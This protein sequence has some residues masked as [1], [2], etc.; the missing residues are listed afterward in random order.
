[1]NFRLGCA[2]FAVR[3]SRSS[4][5]VVMDDSDRL[6]ALR[7]ELKRRLGPERYEL[8]LGPQTE[9]SLAE[10]VLEVRCTSAA[11]GQWLRRRWHEHLLAC[12]AAILGAGLSINYQWPVGPGASASTASPPASSTS[13]QIAKPE[14]PGSSAPAPA[15]MVSDPAGPPAPAALS[16]LPAPDGS[17]RG[18]FDDFVIGD[19][20][21]LA[22]QA[23][24][25]L[26]RQ[27]GLFSPLLIYGP[28]GSGKS[29]LLQAINHHA[30][31][32]RGRV[33]TLQLTAEQFTTQFLEAL[34]ARSLPGF[35]QKTRNLDLLIV[36]DVQFLETKRA[37]LEEL[38]HT[39][40]ALEARGG[41]VV[42][43]SDR[44]PGELKS[45]GAALAGRL[46]AGL[47]VVLAPPDFD[48]RVGI[49]RRM[50]ARMRMTLDDAVIDA[51]AQQAMGSARLLSGAVNRLVAVSMAQR[52][53]IT[54]E[55]A[56]RALAEFTRQHA[57]QI[58]LP[59]IQRAV[60]E[61]FGVEST[62][63][64]SP[65]KTRA[66]AEPRMLAM[67]LARRYTR[68]ALSEIGDFFGRRSHSTVSSAQRKFDELLS[69]G[70]QVIVG[71][72]PCDIEEAVRRIEARL[73]SA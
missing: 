38:L 41:Q 49:L 15:G 70:G 36:D 63:L 67:W 72:E 17:Q 42:L 27:A 34:A 28:H 43:A 29:H 23:G 48:T 4:Q 26:A 1:L 3:A 18:T 58:K 10:G 33:R 52:K 9:L 64:K 24:R 54:V 19:C 44:P 13:A 20:N 11:E 73:R 55:L 62:S 46:S 39:I 30:R 22:A 32:M 35:R 68:A 61:V 56:H 69:R 14:K 51:V 5:D 57:P 16:P 7:Q 53:P 6:S 2:A 66:V 12:G 31:Q 45:L 37:T 40:D 65:R 25:D 50:A 8:W 71:N 59:D 60:C 47:T 21:R